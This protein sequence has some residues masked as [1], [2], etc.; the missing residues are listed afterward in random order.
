MHNDES[1][2]IVKCKLGSFKMNWLRNVKLNIDECIE[3][4]IYVHTTDWN[5]REIRA[6]LASS[7]TKI[8]R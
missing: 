6:L 2:D 5:V 4:I 1:K 7:Y 3:G 8:C